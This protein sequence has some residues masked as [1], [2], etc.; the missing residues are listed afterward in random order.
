M[1][2]HCPNDRGYRISELELERQGGVVQYA[3]PALLCCAARRFGAMMRVIIVDDKS[4]RQS[5]D[6]GRLAYLISRS[7]TLESDAHRASHRVCVMIGRLQDRSACPPETR[8]S[9]AP[10]PPPRLSTRLRQPPQAQARLQSLLFGPPCPQLPFLSK[11]AFFEQ[12]H[13]LSSPEPRPAPARRGAVG[14][15]RTVGFLSASCAGSQR[16]AR[17]ERGRAYAM[18]RSTPG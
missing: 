4:H 17:G 3:S 11:S 14:T 10:R 7:P 15:E 8:G 12:A 13:A 18:R 5:R 16:Q 6:G 1:R 2:R 9:A